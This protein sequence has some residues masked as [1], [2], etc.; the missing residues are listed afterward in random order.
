MES[1]GNALPPGTA[2]SATDGCDSFSKAP[3]LEAEIVEHTRIEQDLRRAE[4]EHKRLLEAETRAR[5]EA[6]AAVRRLRALQAISDA[7]VAHQSIHDLPSEL[8][9]RISELL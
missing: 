6:E 8:L 2:T 3:M 9:V 4:K 7:A 1:Y 5:G